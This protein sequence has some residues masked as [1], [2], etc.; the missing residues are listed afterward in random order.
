M[1][2]LVGAERPPSFDRVPFLQT[3]SAAGSRRVL[4]NEDGMAAPWRLLPVFDWMRRREPLPDEV[5][6][7]LEHGGQSLLLQILELS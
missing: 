3:A 6:A 1:F 5:T 4:R 7:V 2:L